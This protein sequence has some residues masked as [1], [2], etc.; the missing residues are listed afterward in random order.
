[1]PSGPPCQAGRF[2]RVHNAG[3]SWLRAK[4]T[5][6][7]GC[8]PRRGCEPRRGAALARSVGCPHLKAAMGDTDLRVAACPAAVEIA[9]A[10]REPKQIAEKSARTSGSEVASQDELQESWPEPGLATSGSGAAASG[11]EAAASGSGAAASG[12]GVA[13]KLAR[14][15]PRYQWQWGCSQW[16]LARA[17]RHASSQN[18]QGRGSGVEDP[19]SLRQSRSGT[20]ASD[21]DPA[22]PQEPRQGCEPRFLDLRDR[23]SRRAIAS[24]NSEGRAGRQVEDDQ[25][26][27]VPHERHELGQGRPLVREGQH[28]CGVGTDRECHRHRG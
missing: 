8:G 21:E 3:A 16:M 9:E 6:L 27:T 13:G 7:V 25:A 10:L 11:S 17:V 15:R 19:R 23:R 18:S 1:M 26:D 28:A 24:R 2:N 12:S 4:P 5:P 14:A 22:S 20:A